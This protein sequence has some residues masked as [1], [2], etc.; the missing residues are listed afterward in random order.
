MKYLS[1]FIAVLVCSSLH[2]QLAADIDLLPKRHSVKNDVTPE[3]KGNYACIKITDHIGCREPVWIDEVIKIK[4]SD[5]RPHI[6]GNKGRYRGI[7]K[8]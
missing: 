8:K 5:E 3:V 2:A 4:T 1:V 7:L 6:R